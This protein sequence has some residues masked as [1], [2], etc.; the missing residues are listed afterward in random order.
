MCT[1][2]NSKLI[3]FIPFL[4]LLSTCYKDPVNACIN[5]KPFFADFT[6]EERI[7]DSSFVTD[8]T[9]TFVGVTLKAKGNYDSVNWKIGNDPRVFNDLNKSI[10]FSSP[11]GK[12]DIRLIGY[13]KI[14]K[15]CFPNNNGIDTITKS[16]TV[17]KARGQSC[18][19]GIYL[20]SVMGREADTFRVSIAHH[21][22]S[23][24]YYLKNLPKG[25][26]GYTTSDPG[27]APLNF[28]TEIEAAGK[29]FYILDR[30]TLTC[31]WVIDGYGRVNNDSLIINYQIR[32]KGQANGSTEKFIGVRK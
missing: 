10:I 18:I 15:Q 25:C 5:E 20:G 12:I 28:G 26:T 32:V 24:F 23:L 19:S 16:L 14:N 17:L 4:I 1:M 9:V 13:G 29:C 27:T 8:T 30:P 31:N 3:F 21:D 2:K 22:P 6:I 7:R 11:V